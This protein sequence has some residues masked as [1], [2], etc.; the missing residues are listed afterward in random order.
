MQKLCVFYAGEAAGQ[1]G[2]LRVLSGH[3]PRCDTAGR[4][5]GAQAEPQPRRLLVR[6][7][8]GAPPVHQWGALLPH[9]APGS[10][11]FLLLNLSFFLFFFLHTEEYHRAYGTDTDAIS[12]YN[13]HLFLTVVSATIFLGLSQCQ[14]L[15]RTGFDT[16]IL[17]Y[18]G[19]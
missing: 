5:H 3:S 16:T 4:L 13:F 18:C 8:A 15:N 17:R 6:F 14:S 11:K 12:E 7:R 9:Q 19:S 1:N 2:E 10:S